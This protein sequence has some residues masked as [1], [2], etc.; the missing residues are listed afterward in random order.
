MREGAVRVALAAAGLAMLA[1][2]AV[3]VGELAL[4]VGP[5][6]LRLLAWLVGGPLV[7]D[8]LVAPV[9]GA[10]GLALSRFAGP[11]WRAP[12][13]AAATVSGVLALL[14]VPLLWRRYGAP[15][16]PGLHDGD[17]GT[18]LLIALALIWTVAL[19]FGTTRHLRR[20]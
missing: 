19:L 18:G 11:A 6:T 12:L 2:G 14:S 13:T 9:V 16:S 7:H 4:P 17:T 1:W 3:L 8:L 20:K 15:P 5:H 10:A